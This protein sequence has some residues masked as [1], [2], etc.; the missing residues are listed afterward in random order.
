M[1]ILDRIE[2]Q[3]HEAA[4]LIIFDVDYI[5]GEIESLDLYRASYKDLNISSYGRT[6]ELSIAN[7]QQFATAL[8][9]SDFNQFNQIINNHK[10]KVKAKKKLKS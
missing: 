5:P 4:K 8:L 3:C 10:Q 9:V 6:R 1:G 7:A 2:K